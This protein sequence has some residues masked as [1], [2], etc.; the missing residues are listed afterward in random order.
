MGGNDTTNSWELLLA[1]VERLRVVEVASIGAHAL[2]EDAEAEVQRLR[3]ALNEIDRMDPDDF[4]TGQDH[5]LPAFRE[6]NFRAAFERVVRI[7]NRA[8]HGT[9]EYGRPL[10]AS[11]DGPEVTRG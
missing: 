3:A 4:R 10:A 5:L 1:E 6:V 7:V 8:L 9:D 2:L 11:N